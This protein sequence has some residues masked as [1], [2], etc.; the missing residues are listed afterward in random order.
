MYT[1]IVLDAKSH[2]KLAEV[3][4]PHIPDG[5][6]MICHHMTINMGRCEDGPANG[7]LDDTFT[8]KAISLAKDDKVIAVGV[9]TDCPSDNDIKH[10]T[11]AVNRRG[12]G[13]PFHSN[14]LEIWNLI[15]GGGVELTGR[16]RECS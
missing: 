7:K 15:Q 2:A 14:N 3:M 11:V 6:D 9:S 1:A 10:I 16:V 5:W 13:K 8:L 12:G 4:R